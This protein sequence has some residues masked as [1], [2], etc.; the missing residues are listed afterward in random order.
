MIST[1][2]LLQKLWYIHGSK[3]DVNIAP[4]FFIPLIL[5][6]FHNSKGHQGIIHLFKAIR[7]CCWPKLHQN[8]MEH[9]KK[10]DIYVKNLLNM[11]KYP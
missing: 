9:I 10:C 3:H 11:D 8:I 4:C 6:E 7:F 2:G 5:H 1:A